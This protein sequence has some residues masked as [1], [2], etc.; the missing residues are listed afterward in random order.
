M[1]RSAAVVTPVTGR[2]FSRRLTG[3]TVA[4]IEQTKGMQSIGGGETGQHNQLQVR[5][6]FKPLLQENAANPGQLSQPARRHGAVPVE[7]PEAF[8]AVLAQFLDELGAP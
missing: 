7:R 3:I 8:N 1:I 6:P 5:E 4:D 2:I